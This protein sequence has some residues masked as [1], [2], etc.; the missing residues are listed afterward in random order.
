MSR[1]EKKIRD[2]VEPKARKGA[3]A[4]NEKKKS[5]I[6]KKNRDRAELKAR[7]GAKA[8]AEINYVPHISWHTLVPQG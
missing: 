6:E 4:R 5:R 3:K 8:R 7:A 2:R 1:I